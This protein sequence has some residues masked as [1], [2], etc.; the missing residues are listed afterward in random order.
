MK[1]LLIIITTL[2]VMSSCSTTK[3][4]KST[5]IELRNEKKLAEQAVIKKAV[6]SRRFI[7][8]FDRLYFSNGGMIDLIPR[9]NFIIIDG[10]K[11][12]ISAAYLGRQYDIKPIAGISM[13]GETLK[14]ALTNDLSKG[15]YEIKMKVTNRGNS[16]DVYLT[17]DKNGKC[18]A[19]LTNIR[20]D[21]VR[22][23]GYIV[24][25][26]DKI[27]NTPQKSIMI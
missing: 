21:F 26:E 4:A 9:A 19:S 6:E 10:E 18:D 12:I 13:R 11:T 2:M 25:I 5:R 15:M 8:K 23:S 16:F 1:K 22:Y 27:I 7:I 20:I 24:P 17:I 14:Y 3:E